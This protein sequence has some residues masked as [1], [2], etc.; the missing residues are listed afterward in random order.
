MHRLLRAKEY[1]FDIS[2]LQKLFEKMEVA[3]VVA[4]SLC[5]IG[6]KDWKVPKC[7]IDL[8]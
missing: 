7:S 2:R 4:S 6:A 5:K 1:Q 8:H 3:V